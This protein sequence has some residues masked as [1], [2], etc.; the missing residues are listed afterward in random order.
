M[1][2]PTS[3]IGGEALKEVFPDLSRVQKFDP[4][5][6]GKPG[7]VPNKEGVKYALFCTQQNSQLISS[8]RSSA[9]DF[10]CFLSASLTDKQKPS[11]RPEVK[12]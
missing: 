4:N 8:Y 12:F 2:R 9:F 3:A 6:A 7:I 10:P 1:T 11:D 5:P